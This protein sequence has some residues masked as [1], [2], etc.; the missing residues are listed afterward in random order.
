MHNAVP[1]VAGVG[2]IPTQV[3][4]SS[5]KVFSYYYYL[6]IMHRPRLV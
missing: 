2:C 5:F 1:S 6:H 4:V 3:N